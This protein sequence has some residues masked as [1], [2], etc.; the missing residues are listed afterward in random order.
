MS[1]SFHV[2]LLTMLSIASVGGIAYCVVAIVVIRRFARDRSNKTVVGS[3]PPISL[4]KP[5]N[6]AI[7]GLE[8]NLRSFFLQDYPDFE[9]LFAVRTERD[10]AVA[11]IE[12]LMKQYPTIS[13][14]L[15][16]TGNPAYA[17]AKVYSLE[18]LFQL[19]NHELLV[20]TDD[21][22][23]VMPDYLKALAWEFES[24]QADA[25][26]NLYRGVA[27]SDFWSKLEALGMSTEFMAGVV[28]AERLE[29]MRFALGP[30]MAIRA[31]CLQDIGGFGALA[32]YLA[33]DFVLGKKVFET[34]HQLV[35]SAHVINHH[36]HSAGFLNS[37]I[38]RLRWNRSSRVSRP[39]GYVGQGFTYTLPWAVMLLLTAP[40][41]WSFGALAC[42]LA[43]RAWLAW[44][45]G[46]RLLNDKAVLRSLWLIPL[47]D[48][49]SFA[50]WLGGFWGKEIVWRNERYELFEDGRMAP[51]SPRTS[52][53][54]RN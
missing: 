27:V 31:S 25:V 23:S 53:T 43:L 42:S 45:L 37:F 13:C 17:N 33:D 36:V 29:G 41:A 10:S 20:I 52:G 50:S 14:R 11:T 22:V 44:E 32:D 1:G 19:A 49:L 7:P 35:L 39:M 18:H 54:A 2:V 16:V 30:S 47:Q 21:D 51:L 24:N 48:C 6:G 15:T 40:S 26:T 9:I 38:H 34:G 8:T 12:Q 3:F 46:A 4:L 5:V 28:V